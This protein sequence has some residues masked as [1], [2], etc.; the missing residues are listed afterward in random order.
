MTVLDSRVWNPDPWHWIEDATDLSHNCEVLFISK[1]WSVAT[2]YKN[3]NTLWRLTLFRE[4]I[5]LL[6][7]DQLT[8]PWTRAIQF[9]LLSAM[10]SQCIAELRYHSWIY[11]MSCVIYNLKNVL[12][13][14]FFKKHKPSVGRLQLLTSKKRRKF[15][16]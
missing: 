8:L 11:I 3:Y 4:L 15:L 5:L 7:G 13:L 1:S 2:R 10:F 16:F 14:I 6:M 12:W 9:R